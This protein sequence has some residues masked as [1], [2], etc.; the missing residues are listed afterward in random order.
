MT[1]QQ[2]YA[3][4]SQGRSAAKW[5]DI[6]PSGQLVIYW[7][8]PF[9]VTCGKCGA[10]FGK[11]VAYNARREYGIVEHTARH[12][13]PRE[14]FP[15]EQFKNSPQDRF[16]PAHR[17]FW[18]WDEVG[19]RAGKASAHFACQNC[20]VEYVYDLR[21]FGKRLFEGKPRRFTLMP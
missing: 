21:R 20:G 4:A 12:R 19:G 1:I 11:Y 13:H 5:N 2:V 16:E 10:N 7:T 14:N 18:L 3:N 6:E 9:A 15:P 17:K 8:D